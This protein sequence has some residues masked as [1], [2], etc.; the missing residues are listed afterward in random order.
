MNGDSLAKEFRNEPFGKLQALGLWVVETWACC[1]SFVVLHPSYFAD[2]KLHWM[3]IFQDI[4]ATWC[5]C[6]GVDEH[7]AVVRLVEFNLNS[8]S[9]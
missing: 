7:E 8:S 4:H 9:P 2:M 3:Q 5:K 1:L 6:R